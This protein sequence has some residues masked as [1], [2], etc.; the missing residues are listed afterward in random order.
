[1][2]TK[3]FLIAEIEQLDEK[4][5]EAVHRLIQ[6]L[7]EAERKPKKKKS[8]LEKLQEIDVNGPVDLSVNHALYASGEKTFD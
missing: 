7:L 6:Q 4:Y 5:L 1:M 8:L 3:E 2:V